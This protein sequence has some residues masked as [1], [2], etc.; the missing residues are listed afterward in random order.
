MHSIFFSLT[1]T[2]TSIRKFR[3]RCNGLS[4]TP[5]TLVRRTISYAFSVSKHIALR[6]SL[7]INASRTLVSRLIE[8]STVAWW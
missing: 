5:I 3:M 1:I 4:V 8:L 2:P 7:L 6:F